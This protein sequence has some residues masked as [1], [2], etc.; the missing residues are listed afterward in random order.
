[1][2]VKACSEFLWQAVDLNTQ[3][4]KI[5]NGGNLKHITDLESL[6][7]NIMNKGKL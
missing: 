4:N 1:M 7:L 2:L 5:L 3:V 6:K